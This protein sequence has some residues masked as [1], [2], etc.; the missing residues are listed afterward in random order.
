MLASQLLSPAREMAATLHDVA[1]L[2]SAYADHRARGLNTTRAQWGALAKLQRRQGVSQIEL[3]EALEIAPITLARLI[4]R[5]TEA[6]FVERRDDASDRRI[7]RLYLTPQ[8]APAL[9]KLGEVAEQMMQETLEGIDKPT[10]AALKRG[11]ERMKSNL[12]T[13]LNSGA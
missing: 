10:A 13:A 5:L 2:L 1:R 4:D 11:L 3:A 7:H 6:G 8:A 12:K 9:E